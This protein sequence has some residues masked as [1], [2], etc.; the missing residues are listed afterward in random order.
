MLYS[1]YIH[2]RKRHSLH[3]NINY[4]A[5]QIIVLTIL[6]NNYYAYTNGFAQQILVLIYY[7]YYFAQQILVLIYYFAQQL[8]CAD[9]SHFCHAQSIRI[10]SVNDTNFEMMF[11]VVKKIHHFGNAS[12]L[13]E[14]LMIWRHRLEGDRPLNRAAPSVPI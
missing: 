1:V 7:I 13:L 11:S 4:F 6:H 3:K 8:Y 10:S 9:A 5:Q 2:S 14:Y 12:A